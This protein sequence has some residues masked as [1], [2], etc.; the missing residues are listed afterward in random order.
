VPVL[1]PSDNVVGVLSL[2]DVLTKRRATRALKTARKVL[3]RENSGPHTP[4]DRI[5]LTPS[6]P[7][8]P[9]PLETDRY[10]ASRTT[11]EGVSVSIGRWPGVP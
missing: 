10:D 2:S 9:P 7:N 5:H 8:A 4:L 11:R 1:G 3:A 6:D